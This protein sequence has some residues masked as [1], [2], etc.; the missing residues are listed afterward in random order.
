MAFQIQNGVL[1]QYSEEKGVT[2]ISIPEGITEI[3]EWAFCGCHSLK[4]IHLPDSVNFIGEAAFNDCEFLESI[5]LPDGVTEISNYAFRQCI[6]LKHVTIPDSVTRIGNH[7]FHNCEQ[8]NTIHLPDSVT[9]IGESAFENC[10][11][12]TSVHLSSNVK[13]IKNYVFSDCDNLTT[14][15]VDIPISKNGETVNISLVPEKHFSDVPLIDQIHML[16]KK[17]FSVKMKTET[18]YSLLCRFLVLCPELPKLVAYMKK[19]F[20]EIFAFAIEHNFTEAI[21]I[22][23]NWNLLN[24]GN[25]DG[26]IRLA[27]EN[28]QKTGN[29]EIQLALTEYKYKHIEFTSIEDKFKL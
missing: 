25:I 29:P 15:L 27:I 16:R 21:F 26:F 8:L 17:K 6:H 10:Q 20:E 3:G 13:T 23:L 14:I 7:A 18:K 22:M 19:H 12:L 1:K 2:E 4:I 28:T 9:K 11:N 5:H 24:Q